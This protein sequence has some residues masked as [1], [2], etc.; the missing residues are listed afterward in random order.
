MHHQIADLECQL[1]VAEL[2]KNFLYGLVQ[3]Q[4]QEY[5]DVVIWVRALA[6]LMMLQD[7]AMK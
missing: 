2:H 4:S 1:I 6:M 7:S 5:Q 3:I